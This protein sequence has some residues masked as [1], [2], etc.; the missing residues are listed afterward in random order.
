[1]DT[2]SVKSS[3]E[4]W[5][6][7]A[8]TPAVI[9]NLLLIQDNSDYIHA[10]KSYYIATGKGYDTTNIGEIKACLRVLILSLGPALKKE[11]GDKAYTELKEAWLKAKTVDDLT[12][13][14]E[15]VA[16]FLYSK[17]VTKF[18]RVENIDIFDIAKHN[19][20]VSG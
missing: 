9:L 14:Y 10:E 18:D 2:N 6:S 8:N 5:I 20:K 12:E 15:G 17:G 7:T 1:M 3:R 16:D 11:K 19:R 4:A 13:I